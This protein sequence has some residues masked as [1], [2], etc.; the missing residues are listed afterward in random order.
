[1]SLEKES[2]RRLCLFDECIQ[3]QETAFVFQCLPK[4][5]RHD[6]NI[7]TDGNGK[8]RLLLLNSS[9]LLLQKRKKK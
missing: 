3:E 8:T 1:M 6:E 4:G 5:E 9:T 7:S 2:G